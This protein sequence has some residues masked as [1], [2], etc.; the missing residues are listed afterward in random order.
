MSKQEKKSHPLLTD[1]QI[2]TLAGAASGAF[3]S[4]LVSPLDVIKTRIQVKRL[5]K[6]VPDTGLLLTIYR[7][8]Q[9]EGFQAFFKGLGTT[10][11][12]RKLVS[13]IQFIILSKF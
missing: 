2:N 12:V 11:L 7:L 3:V 5:P 1:S 13:F 9:R 6:G 8:G 10:M 4:V